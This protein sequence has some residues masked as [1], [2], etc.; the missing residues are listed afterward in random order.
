MVRKSVKDF[1]LTNSE[2]DRRAYT[3]R[4][5]DFRRSVAELTKVLQNPRRADLVAQ[6]QERFMAYNDAFMSVLSV[7]EERNALLEQL[8]EE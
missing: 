4:A 6:M 8:T 7:I 5:D 1:L 2:A 3:A